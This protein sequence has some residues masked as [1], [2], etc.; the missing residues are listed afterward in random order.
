MTSQTLPPFGD[1]LRQHR[2]AAG[3]SQEELAEIAGISA[4]AISDLER[5][6]RHRPYRATVT[7]LAQALGLSEEERSALQLAARGQTV[8]PADEVTSRSPTSVHTFFIADVRGYTQFTLD[9]GDEAAALLTTRFAALVEAVVDAWDGQVIELQGDEALAV[10]ASARQALRAAVE[11]QARLGEESFPLGV[12][13]GLDAGEAVEVRGGYRGAAL[14]LAARLCSLARAGEVLAS[15]GVTHLARKV[16]GLAY[17]ERGSVRLKGFDEPV[18]VIEVTELQ[19]GTRAA[20]TEALPDGPQRLPVGGFLGSLPAGALVARGEELSRLL[21]ALEE[22]AAGEGRLVLLAGEPG[23]GKTR[24]AQ[25]LTRAAHDQGFL[26]AAGRC[27]EPE[28]IVPYY[29][30]LDAFATLWDIAPAAIRAGAARRWPHLGAL[31]PEALPVPPPSEIPGQDDQQRVFRALTGFL[32][33]MAERTPIL[34]LLDDLHWADGSSLKLLQHLATHTRSCRLLLLGSYRDVEVGR[35][36]PL[37]GALLDLRRDG[38]AETI[39][40]QRL[41]P[42]GTAALVAATLG[43][44][45][46]PP[47]LAE[48]LH[49]RTEG[50]P[51]FITQVLDVLLHGNGHASEPGQWDRATVERLEVPESIRAVV[52]RRLSQLTP[53]T[54]AILHEA[55]VL[56]QR[57]HFDDLQQLTRRTEEDVET[58]LEEACHHRILAVAPGDEYG[59]DHVLTQQ[60]LHRE[61]PARRKRRLHLLAGEMLE[62]RPEAQREKRVAELARHFLQADEP[63]RAMRYAFAAADQAAHIF[64][65]AEA[66]HQY[67]TA[68]SLAR[69][70]GNKADEAAALERLGQ[71]LTATAQYDEALEHLEQAAGIYRA[72]GDLEHEV[73]TMGAIAEVHFYC[74]RQSDGVARVEAFLDALQGGSLPA[75]MARLQAYHVLNTFLAQRA[76]LAEI[77]PLSEQAAALAQAEGDMESYFLA[78]AARTVALRSLGREEEAVQIADAVVPLAEER[79]D[80]A[81]LGALMMLA[82]TYLFTSRFEQARRQLERNRA[83]YER[84]GNSDGVAYCWAHIGASYVGEGDWQQA[85]ASYEQAMQ[86]RD[87]ESHSWLAI[88]PLIGFGGLAVHE[89]RWAEAEPVLDEAMTLARANQDG[90]WLWRVHEQLIERGLLRGQVEE[91]VELHQR[92]MGDPE[93]APKLTTFPS[94]ALAMASLAVEDVETVEELVE[95][96]IRFLGEDGLDAWLWVWIALR[97]RVLAVRERWEES[98]STFL[99]AIARVR[100]TRNVFCEAQALQWHGEML[101][102]HGEV[103]R[104]QQRLREAREIYARVGAAPYLEQTEK[105]LERLTG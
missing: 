58:A 61:L 66:E 16:D 67:R 83:T 84:R 74:G 73:Q 47:A 34:L 59:F 12:G 43:E 56:G 92:L 69:E 24:L 86:T 15:E 85:R 17:G 87:V 104:A 21:T 78:E 38:L 41:F 5:G 3:L 98:E 31:L 9:Q 4:R 30:F 33:T 25:E 89:G 65:H 27:Y 81:S 2:L 68:L 54:Q 13:V 70:V 32:Q 100:R 18:K 57:F 72:A 44:A 46:V 77:V 40:V 60:V 14:N 93:Q 97:A 11:L 29:P 53:E 22:A 75:G 26:V 42:D 94:P 76:S 36:H 102:A 23:I 103:D 96:G 50:N 52:G 88:L 48:R 49:A 55:G 79:D 51:F 90:Q 95:S 62:Q 7:Q 80:E 63:G 1:L 20:D 91:A 101:A 105:A 71:V 64:A 39:P 35:Q 99:D 10:F 82:E 19:K 45:T 6:A 37:E 28:Q 8:S